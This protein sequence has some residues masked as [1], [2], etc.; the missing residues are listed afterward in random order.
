M[1]FS[2]TF[3][4]PDVLDYALS[5]YMDTH[6]QS[7]EEHDQYCQDCI[8]LEENSLQAIAR[9]KMFAKKFVQYEEYITIDFDTEE[10]TATARKLK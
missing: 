8:A 2:L 5:K 1:K 4:T 7:C 6:C 9:I 3:K 10:E